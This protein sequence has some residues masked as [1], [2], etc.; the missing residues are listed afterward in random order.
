MVPM[1]A[2]LVTSLHPKKFNVYR[3]GDGRNSPGTQ[4]AKQGSGL[5]RIWRFCSR[6]VTGSFSIFYRA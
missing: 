5:A 6:R 2:V 1:L 4:G 3:E